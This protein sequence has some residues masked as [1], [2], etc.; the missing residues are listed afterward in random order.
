MRVVATG[1][2][3]PLFDAAT[4][5]IDGFDPDITVHGLHEIWRRSRNGN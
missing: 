5:T 2:L 3:A 1:G 4:E